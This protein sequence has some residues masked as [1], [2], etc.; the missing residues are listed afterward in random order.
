MLGTPSHPALT[1]CLYALTMSLLA[2]SPRLHAFDN[3]SNTMHDFC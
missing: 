2:I 1:P 3:P